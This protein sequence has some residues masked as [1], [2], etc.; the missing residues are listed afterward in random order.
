LA[1]V[2]IALAVVACWYDVP[3]VVTDSGAPE[4]AAD[5]PSSDAAADADAGAADA[6]DGGCNPDAPFG[7][8][9]VI[10]GLANPT[11]DERYP[12]LSPDELTIYF[13]FGPPA[14]PFVLFTASRSSIGAAFGTPA[15]IAGLT[16]GSGSDN[17][18]T[19]SP[20]GLVALMSSTR[21]QT[22]VNPNV[23]QIWSTS[24]NAPDASFA[25]PVWSN[26]TFGTQNG[27]FDP[28]FVG[29]SG[30]FYYAHLPMNGSID[31]SYAVFS[32]GNYTGATGP[33]IAN[34]NSTAEDRSPTLT[35]DELT[36]Y[37]S[38]SRG[39]TGHV[40]MSN[41]PSNA[42]QFQAPWMVSELSSLGNPRPGW[43]SAN[44]CRLYLT[45]NV[46]GNDDIYLAQRGK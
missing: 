26:T 24:R 7:A 32:G 18:I 45:I 21:T 17:N 22:S 15:P 38:S 41:R 5:A 42:V 33:S 30:L 13:A 6:D 25:A 3:D 27:D 14:G 2:A 8:P 37:F 23:S 20:N 36:I 19:V 10:A 39:G 29:S 44:N 9:V 28:Y 11:Y 1:A 12:R 35:P 40:W 43:I 46:S 4:A 16:G 34:L 31:L